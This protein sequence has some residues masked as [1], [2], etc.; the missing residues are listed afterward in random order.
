MGH[1]SR[2]SL[3]AGILIHFRSELVL[4]QR[5]NDQRHDLHL[6]SPESKY[7]TVN[8][9][10]ACTSSLLALFVGLVVPS[11]GLEYGGPPRGHRSWPLILFFRRRLSAPAHQQGVPHL[12]HPSDLDV[13]AETVG[14]L[15]F[16]LSST[17]FKG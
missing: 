10:H 11:C 13:A 17:I 16:K 4:L 5:L 9:L 6:G 2:F 7:A 15:S 8:F 3:R 14:G 1:F 12:P